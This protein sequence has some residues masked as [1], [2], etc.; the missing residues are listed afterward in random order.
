MGQVQN[1]G[2]PKNGHNKSNPFPWGSGGVGTL[3]SWGSKFVITL[4]IFGDKAFPLGMPSD[5]GEHKG[6]EGKQLC[7][8]VF[9]IK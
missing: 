4:E 7:P 8:L 6:A 1:Q 9:Q 2:A 3:P 5:R